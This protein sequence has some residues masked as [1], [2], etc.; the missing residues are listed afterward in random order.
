M[1]K[2]FSNIWNAIKTIFDGMSITFSYLLQK[3][4]T[5]QYPDRT[6][7]PVKDTLPDPWEEIRNVLDVGDVINVAVSNIEPYGVFVDIGNDIEGFLHIS[8][9]SW[10]KNIKNPKEYVTLDEE[11]DV[12]VIEIDAQSR[13]LRVS[14]KNLKPKPFEEFLQKYKTGDIVKCAYK[15]LSNKNILLAIQKVF[16]STPFLVPAI[17]G[18]NA[19]ESLNYQNLS[20]SIKPSIPS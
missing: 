13:R 12:E 1:K 7:K 5:V 3:P 4:I 17:L 20:I 2:Y 11:L 18:G 10:D 19:Y 16:S 14:L 6:E 8:E 9:I 15:K